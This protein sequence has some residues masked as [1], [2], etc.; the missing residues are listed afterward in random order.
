MNYEHF[1]RLEEGT[2]CQGETESDQAFMERVIAPVFSED[3]PEVSD[4]INALLHPVFAGC[5][6]QR[7]EI[8]ATFRA[9]DWM[10]NPNGT[11]HGGMLATSI[12]VVMSVLARFLAR[13][14]ITVTVQLSTNFLR[15][16]RQ[17]EKY[18]V[19]VTADHAGRR[20]IVT[21]AVVYAE[22]SEKP[23]ATATGVLM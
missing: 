20:S 12:D 11:L 22:G 23:A 17:G 4:R 14:R 1:A 5:D 3:V 9:E 6:A 19:H 13:K 2:L 7:K 16:I 8:S 18:T 21:H 15:V 10:L